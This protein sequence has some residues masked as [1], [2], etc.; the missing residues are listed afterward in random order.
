M[1]GSNRELSWNA[2][3]KANGKTKEHSWNFQTP[4]ITFRRH[5]LSLRCLQDEYMYKVMDPS[6]I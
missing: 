3:E 4:R 1:K 2:E 6:L 5:L